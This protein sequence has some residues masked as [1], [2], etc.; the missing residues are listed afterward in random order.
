[1]E[2]IRGVNAG[3][4]HDTLFVL[5]CSLHPIQARVREA[6]VRRLAELDE[7]Q[8]SN[9]RTEVMLEISSLQ[10]QSLIPLVCRPDVT[11]LECRNSR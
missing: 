5:Y 11:M 1:M 4:F 10:S 2:W 3:L 9:M 6:A 8:N 7:E